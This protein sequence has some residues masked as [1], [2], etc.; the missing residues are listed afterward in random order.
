MDW[1]MHYVNLVKVATAGF[2]VIPAIFD[3]LILSAVIF[4]VYYFIRERRAGKLAWGAFVFFLILVVCSIF[5]FRAMQFVLSSFL[6]K[7]GVFIAI[8][9]Q[10]EIRSALE[11]LGINSIKG[12]KQIGEQ[13]NASPT[14]AMIDEL[15]DAV[16]DLSKTKT[17]ALIVFERNTKLGD[18][19]LTGTIVN[20]QFSSTLLR[21][22]FFNKAPLHDGAVVV[23]SNRIHS[24]GCL[25]PLESNRDVFTDLGTRHRAAVGISEIS[26]CVSVVVSEETGIISV[27]HEGKLYRNFT[28]ETLKKKLQEY[29]IKNSNEQKKKI[30]SKVNLDTEE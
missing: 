11:K 18:V 24:A 28:K 14:N 3:V 4:A 16:S 19:I 22:I 9:F 21:S 6:L 7:Y 23:R 2:S 27:A 20:A 26:D 5:N 10:P 17:G 12:I 8:I 25:L 13:K 1:F 15:A 30:T 29:L